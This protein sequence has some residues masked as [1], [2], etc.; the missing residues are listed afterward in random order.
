MFLMHAFMEEL[1]CGH[2][3]WYV[4]DEFIR[5]QLCLLVWDWLMRFGDGWSMG[6]IGTEYGATGVT[7]SELSL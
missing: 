7:F 6:Y 4:Y 3:V 1:N 5:Y 2:L